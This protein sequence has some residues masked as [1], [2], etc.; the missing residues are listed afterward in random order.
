VKL[1]RDSEWLAVLSQVAET[2]QAIGGHP[3][4]RWAYSQ[5]LPY[6]ARFVVEGIGAA[7]RGSV[8]HYLGL[9][10]SVLDEPVK[11]VE[12]AARAEAAHRRIGLTRTVESEVP[13]PTGNIFRR[14]GDIWML[15][16]AGRVVRLRHAKGLADL[17]QLLARPGREVPAL[18]LAMPMAAAARDSSEPG[19]HPPGD[20][21]EVLDGQARAAY[22]RRLAELEDELADPDLD[23]NPVWAERARAERDALVDQLV[24]AY[25]LAGRPR[26]AGDP[27][28]RA[29][30]AVTARLRAALNRIEA[31]H[32]E[33]G[34]HLRHSVR[35]GTLC[36][37]APEKPTSWQL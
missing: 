6:R 1:P 34:R 2:V 26:R 32:P 22:K 28:E 35:T 31:A 16:Y 18:D 23:A 24:G 17:A 25:G 9:L 33:L 12:H 29:R 15:G 4:A 11:A 5:L 8:E 7:F 27:A 14:E 21:G 37:Y 3:V 19:L 36:V 10:A 13:S 20:L 30:T